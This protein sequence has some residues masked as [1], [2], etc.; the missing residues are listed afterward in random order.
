ML[1]NKKLEV[2]KAPLPF[3]LAGVQLS[4]SD[5]YFQPRPKPPSNAILEPN[6]VSSLKKQWSFAKPG[7]SG[8]IFHFDRLTGVCRL[9]ISPFIAPELLAI[10][11]G[12]GHPGFSRYHKII[13]R[14][15]FI[16]DLTKL[17]R[18]FIRYCL[19]CLALQTRKY[20]LY[21]LF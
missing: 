6:S 5:P 21:N 7:T 15:W 13:S 2:D 10:A 18:S 12:K 14:S 4:D 8:L 1:D 20:T 11:H 19:Q 17:L 16:R 9:C 3:I